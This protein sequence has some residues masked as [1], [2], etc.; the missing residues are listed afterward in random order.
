MSI[1]A[2]LENTNPILKVSLS[3]CDED[4]NRQ[5]L[6]DNLIET[7]KEY[8]GIGLSANQCGVMARVFVMY[9]DINIREIISCF[10]PWRHM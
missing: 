4:L 9:S 10:N 8:H 3:E 5:E 6:K 7:M 2:L 1:Y